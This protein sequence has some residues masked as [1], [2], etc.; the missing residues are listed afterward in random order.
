MY[1]IQISLDSTPNVTLKENINLRL[2][3][4]EYSFSFIHMTFT[5][6]FDWKKKIWFLHSAS[7]PWCYHSSQAVLMLLKYKWIIACYKHCLQ[8]KN[9]KTNIIQLHTISNE[10]FKSLPDPACI[11]S[12]RDNGWGQKPTMEKLENKF[13]L[14]NI[15]KNV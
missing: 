14:T 13:F 1:V 3:I 15:R 8:L 9:I 4:Y 6:K 12:S 5:S 2:K 11:M 10:K 7:R